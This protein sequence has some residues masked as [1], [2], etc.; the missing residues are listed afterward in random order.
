MEQK[1]YEEL[2]ER[3]GT[4]EI[5]NIQPLGGT[6]DKVM[7]K[8]TIEEITKFTSDSEDEEKPR[9]MIGWRTI[10]FYCDRKAIPYI[11]K[12]LNNEIL[13]EEDKICQCTLF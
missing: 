1:I 12:R 9:G 10:V 3:V 8:I 2:L 6:A 5:I 11:T 13:L 4:N 7:L